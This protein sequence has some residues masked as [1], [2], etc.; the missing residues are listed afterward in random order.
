M[1]IKMTHSDTFRCSPQQ[2]WPW[3]DDDEKSKQWLKGLEEIRPVS[4]GPKRP[5]YEA[6][7]FI[8][9]GRKLSEY[10]VTYLAYEPNKRLRMK[11]VGGCG[12]GAEFICDYE[13]VDLHDGRTRVDFGCEVNST[14]RV[15]RLLSP[16]FKLFSRMMLKRFLRKL[17]E[18]AEGGTVRAAH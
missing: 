8:R 2:L 5:G 4:G 3:I 16:L 18:L 13:L 11:S 1:A 6:K 10:D 17:K 7:M 9:E 14:S 15:L 12:K